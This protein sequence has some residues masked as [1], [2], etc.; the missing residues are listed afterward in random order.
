M[1]DVSSGRENSGVNRL[2]H[3]KSP[4]LVQ[5]AEQPVDWYPWGEAAFERARQE[6][7]PVLVSI[8]YSTCHWCH[9][10][11][12]ESFD[13]PGIAD[14][15][16][17]CFISVKVDREERP[18]VDALYI[19]AVS[20][21]TG[22][23]GWPLNVFLTPDGKPFFG[24]TY[25]PPQSRPGIPGWTDVLQQIHQAWTDPEQRAKITSSADAITQRLKQHLSDAPAQ[26]SQSD[27]SVQ[28]I[29]N[30]VQAFAGDYDSENGGFGNAPKFPMPPILKFLLAFYRFSDEINPSEPLKEQS[31]RMVAAS[32][33]AMA[34]GGIYDHLG[35]GFHRYS[36]DQFWHVPHFE[37]MLYDNA[38]LISVYADA[39]RI[40][41][42]SHYEDVVRQTINYV[43]RD[44][45]HPEGAFY[46]AE[47]ADSVPPDSGEIHG[48]RPPKREGAFYVWPHAEIMAFLE[49]S[50]DS[51][52]AD[53][54]SYL[55]DIRKNG[56]V[57]H[58]PFEEFKGRNVLHQVHSIES[59]AARFNLPE[60]KIRE[61]LGQA[62]EKLFQARL[63]RPRP[64][65][66][67]KILTA[68]NGLMISALARA[69][70][71]FD[72]QD[73]LSAA[74]RAAGFIYTQLY[75]KENFRLYR[76][77]RAGEAKISG[78]A[79]DYVFLINGLIDLYELNFNPW[80]LEWAVELM[81]QFL[82]DFVDRSTGL[83]YLTPRAHDPCLAFQMKDF[84]DNV[85]PSAGSGAA[86]GLVRLSRI[87]GN[88]DFDTAA[89]TVFCY[90]SGEI[91]RYPKMAPYLLTA[92]MI[93]MAKHVHMVIAGG[94]ETVETGR[95]I[96]AGRRAG[97]IGQSMV[98]VGDATEREKLSRILPDAAEI[99]IPDNG[100]AAQVCFDRTCRPP[101]DT[102][103]KLIAQL[104]TAFD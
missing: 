28:L 88:K 73:Y 4:Y 3:E 82:A 83:V 94:R 90:A 70:E 38:Q 80:L 8:G 35:G 60:A 56:N 32:L 31:L 64:H 33:D 76:R 97:G 77:W 96:D 46:S 87:T 98:V 81:N 37:K 65:L 44:M 84:I 21:L 54:F 79:D 66:D 1:T 43:L 63:K 86:L 14:L 89:E 62:R 18:D 49:N 25:F 57:S 91:A 23:A 13:D 29:T 10:M 71:V 55:Y 30:S 20:S 67:D 34:A 7:K 75:D 19:T 2:I 103:E 93:S 36:T 69:A 41:G 48:G 15:M 26:A 99:K 40:T 59:A 27:M 17:R 9:V 50:T 102:P 104:D 6:D 58:D 85:T 53:I 92:V 52:E 61:I 100:A 5:H 45:T 72:S 51:P 42:N 39:Y 47:D 16:N 74:E 68:W 101:V 24:G 78:L 12:E 22:S 95:L 11:A